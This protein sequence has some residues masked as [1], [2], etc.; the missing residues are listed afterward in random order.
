MGQCP[1]DDGTGSAAGCDAQ[2]VV[3]RVGPAAGEAAAL[4]RIVKS[5][6]RFK[7]RSSNATGSV[8]P[9]LD[10][11]A[12]TPSFLVFRFN[13]LKAFKF[14]LRLYPSTAE[15]IAWIYLQFTS[16]NE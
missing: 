8:L 4:V 16:A 9:R 5:M 12:K 3:S 11:D 13:L 10:E 2:I 1:G 7:L 15:H 6:M 14:E